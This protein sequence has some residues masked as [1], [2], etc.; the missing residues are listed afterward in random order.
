MG[1]KLCAFG[2]CFEYVFLLRNFAAAFFMHRPV[3]GKYAMKA[4]HGSRGGYI[5]LRGHPEEKYQQKFRGSVPGMPGCNRK[6]KREYEATG[7]PFLDICP[8]NCKGMKICTGI[9]YVI[10]MERKEFYNGE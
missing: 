4:V 5:R 1:E 6:L 9:Q 3:Q 10:C 2:L 7:L 8:Q